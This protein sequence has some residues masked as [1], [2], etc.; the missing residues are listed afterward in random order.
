VLITFAPS[1]G[2]LLDEHQLFSRYGGEESIVVF[3][4]LSQI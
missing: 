3:P 2:A 4:A 1:P